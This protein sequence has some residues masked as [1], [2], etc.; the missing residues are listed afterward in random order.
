MLLE[1]DRLIVTLPLCRQRF[2]EP[3]GAASLRAEVRRVQASQR[4]SRP[5]VEQSKIARVPGRWASRCALL[6]R[7]TAQKRRE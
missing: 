1:S 6:L 3:R 7:V 2:R 4:R 5:A